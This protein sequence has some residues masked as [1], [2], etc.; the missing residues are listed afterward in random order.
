[1][2]PTDI[3]NVQEYR[4]NNIG[5]NGG[6]SS[7]RQVQPTGAYTATDSDSVHIQDMNKRVNKHVE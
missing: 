6:I 3:E 1:M 2:T 5:I 7:N 4:V